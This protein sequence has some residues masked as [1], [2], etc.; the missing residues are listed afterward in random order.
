MNAYLIAF[1]GAL[2]EAFKTF[3]LGRRWT[4]MDAD[5]VKGFLI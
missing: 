3:E 5:K 2:G 4:Q 1:Q